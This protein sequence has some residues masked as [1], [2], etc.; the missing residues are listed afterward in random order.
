MKKLLLM[1]VCSL[2]VGFVSAGNDVKTKDVKKLPAV[3]QRFISKYFPSEKI[4]QIKIDKE[5]MQ[6]KDY[7]V[8]FESGTEIEFGSNGEW[9][10][11]DCQKGTVPSAL[12]PAKITEHIKKEFSG[13]S[14]RSISRD[15]KEYEL[16]LS[17]GMEVKYDLN[18]NF[19]GVD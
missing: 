6:K 15:K 14:I 11:I 2:F 10:D 1:A 3:S 9:K 7:E 17:D 19:I 5:A 12:V 8:L 18:G 13:K 4:A 16:K